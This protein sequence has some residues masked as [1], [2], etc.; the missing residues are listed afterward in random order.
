MGR[1]TL[2][3]TEAAPHAPG[4]VGAV[5]VSF[6]VED[7]DPH[8]VPLLLVLAHSHALQQLYGLAGN[9]TL[10]QTRRTGGGR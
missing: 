4:A 8:Q 1:I 10:N 7:V 2:V 9:L 6:N 5:D 3:I